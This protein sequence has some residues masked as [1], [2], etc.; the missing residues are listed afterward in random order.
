MRT[1]AALRVPVDGRIRRKQRVTAV[2]LGILVALTVG[3]AAAQ[4]GG[5]SVISRRDS[6][7]LLQQ[8]ERQRSGSTIAPAAIP[9]EAAI[10]PTAYILSPGDV[11]ALT[12]WG[13][14]ELFYDLS[15]TADGGLLVP[16]VGVVTVNGLTLADA[17]E[18]LRQECAAAY[19]RS[20][21]VLSLV[22]PAVLRIPITG[23]VQMPGIHQMR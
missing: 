17:E 13:S 4:T 16:A 6:R 14:V 12:I 8:S 7:D 9:L 15:V 10:D 19:P 23:L 20:E 21:V 18:R 3:S 2:I 1:A 5:W 22:R 11:L